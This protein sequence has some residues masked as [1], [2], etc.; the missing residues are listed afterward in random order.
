M[1]TPKWV[2]RLNAA[3]TRGD[4]LRIVNEYVESRDQAV[5]MHLPVECRITPM[6]TDEELADCAYRLA[7]YHGHGD[8][9]RLV[10][11]FATFFTRASIRLGELALQRPPVASGSPDHP[12]ESRS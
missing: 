8:L 5:L 9:S 4:V 1:D 10:N 2:A 12:T 6:L 11:R 3:T 7:A